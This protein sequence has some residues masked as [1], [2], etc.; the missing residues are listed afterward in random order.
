MAVTDRKFQS[1][2]YI[3]LIKTLLFCFAKDSKMAAN[4][5]TIHPALLCTGIKGVYMC[6]I[7]KLAI[8]N[9]YSGFSR[10]QYSKAP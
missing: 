6:S 7:R 1:L 3:S 10:K 2:S 9:A 4:A 5:Y 8:Y